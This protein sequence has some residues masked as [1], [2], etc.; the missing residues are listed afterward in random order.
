MNFKN[1]Y[2]F[3]ICLLMLQ[4]SFAK[5]IY[6]SPK[7]NDTNNGTLKAPFKTIDKARLAVQKEIQKGLTENVQVYLMGGT[8]VLDETI[9]FGLK[10]SPSGDFTVTYQAYKNEKPVLSSGQAVS[11]WTL[12]K[13]VEGM[14]SKAS[15][16]VYV[17]DMPEGL[18]TFRTLFDGSSMLTRARGADFK[19]PLKK[20]IRRADSQNTYYHKDRIH[21]RMVP[22]PNDE[23]K[24]WSNLSDVEVVFNPVPWNLNI[25]Q[26]ESVDVENKVGYL[27]F[28]ANA[29][30]FTNSKHSI[31][32]V[33]N[34]IDYLDEPGEWC[35]NTQTRK[36]YY[37]PKNGTPSKN[38]VAPKLMELVKVEGKIQYDLNK[39]IPAKNIHFK[40]L[41]VN[42]I[43]VV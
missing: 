30:P 11:N 36:I 35:V 14:S 8:Y 7:G 41:T 13:N 22:Y 34:V 28:E 1:K 43:F 17:A 31:A 25:I 19:M 12:A 18:S 6:V 27:A 26:L 32:W 24:N 2:T 39:D 42:A 10:D 38:I 16:K 5:D 40:G 4:S 15:G 20:E 23:I 29:M 3:I 21:L 33:E 37:W 9:V